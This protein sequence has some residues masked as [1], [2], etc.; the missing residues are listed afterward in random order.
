MVIDR[1]V[2][3][4]RQAMVWL[5]LSR[6]RKVDL[7]GLSRPQNGCDPYEQEPVVLLAEAVEVSRVTEKGL[8]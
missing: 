5:T 8:W 3:M 2:W 7:G 6:S 4:F 1:P